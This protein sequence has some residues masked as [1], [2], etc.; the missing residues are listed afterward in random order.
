MRVGG[1]GYA[2]RRVSAAC[3]G[4]MRRIVVVALL[5]G[6]VAGCSGGPNLAQD[7]ASVNNLTAQ[8]R[9]DKGTLSADQETLTGDQS[10]NLS[11]PLAGLYVQTNSSGTRF[12]SVPSCTAIAD[13]L[14][15]SESATYGLT[16]A[17]AVGS[18]TSGFGPEAGQRRPVQAP[19]RSGPV[20]EGRGLTALSRERKRRTSPRSTGPGRPSPSAEVCCMRSGVADGVAVPP[21]SH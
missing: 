1:P 14:T 3:E 15:Q 16:R 13:P 11:V 17:C 9:A 19:G 18:T 2:Y 8:V 10:G 12:R 21:T 6:F 20:E 7:Q 5:A 4:T